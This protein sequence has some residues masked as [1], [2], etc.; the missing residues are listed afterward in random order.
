MTQ[1]DVK[2]KWHLNKS[3]PITVILTILLSVGAGTTAIW[4]IRKDVDLHW[5]VTSQQIS[6]LNKHIAD[7]KQLT[8][9][10]RKTTLMV[11]EKLD[12]KLDS[13]RTE[14]NAIKVEQALRYGSFISDKK[15]K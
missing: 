8:A 3:V 12:G 2:E 4:N 5:Q 7:D 10:A 15:K 13:I 6:A 9:N 1:Q 14:L 11:L